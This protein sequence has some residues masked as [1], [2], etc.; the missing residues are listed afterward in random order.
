M[1]LKKKE[2][3]RMEEYLDDPKFW[4]G[5]ISLRYVQLAAYSSDI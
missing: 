4:E 3:D 1:R 2:I 5:I